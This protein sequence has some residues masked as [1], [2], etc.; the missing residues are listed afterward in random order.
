MDEVVDEECQE[1]EESIDL[2]K[3][4]LELMFKILLEKMP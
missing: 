2:L 4:K 3:M 1:V